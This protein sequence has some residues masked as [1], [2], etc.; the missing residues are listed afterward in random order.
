[1]MIA[2]ESYGTFQTPLG[3]WLASYNVPVYIFFTLF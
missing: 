1:M 3:D 2:E